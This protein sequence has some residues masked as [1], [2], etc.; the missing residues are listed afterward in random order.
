MKIEFVKETKIDG[1]VIY[2]TQVDGNY[3]SDSLSYDI[4][5]AKKVYDN[6]VKNK[7]KIDFKEVLESIEVAE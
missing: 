1:K 3:T 6:I 4:D 5:K 7:G 2:F